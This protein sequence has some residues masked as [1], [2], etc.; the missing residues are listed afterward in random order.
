[1]ELALN[2][3]ASDD[4]SSITLAV[5]LKNSVFSKPQL[6]LAYTLPYIRQIT[7]KD[8]L[9]STEKSAQYLSIVYK[10]RESELNHCSLHLKLA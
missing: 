8:L 5:L 2:F 6:G 1:M 9:Y 4:S 10:G 7:N 3:I